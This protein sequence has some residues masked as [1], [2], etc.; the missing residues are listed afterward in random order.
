M[1]KI[2]LLITIITVFI[3]A[4]AE[5]GDP[6]SFY[7][8]SIY[9]MDESVF[10]RSESLVEI[11][12]GRP[13]VVRDKS[14]NVM[15]TTSRGEVM[16][17]IDTAGEM[18]FSIGGRREHHRGEDGEIEKR[19]VREAGTS[20][21]RVENERQE[22]L[23]YEEYGYGGKLVA[24]YDTE[25]NLVRSV[26]YNE[27]GK[28]ATL[29]VD[30]LTMSRTVHDE[31]GRAV[32][33]LDFEGNEVARYSYDDDT[34]RLLSRTDAYSNV[35]YFNKDG[36]MS[37]TYNRYGRLIA[38]YNYGKNDRGF[39]ALK[40][41]KNEESEIITFY[42]DGRQLYSVDMAGNIVTEFK[43]VGSRLVYSRELETDMI[44]WYNHG[45]PAYVTYEGKVEEKFYYEKGRLIGR[46]IEKDLTV[47]LYSHGMA[48]ATIGL[49]IADE[50]KPDL[51]EV[52]A[53]RRRFM[54]FEA[55]HYQR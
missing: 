29:T 14:G 23:A 44:T 45:R 52:A 37:E 19:W 33:E 43:W 51:E 22:T 27:Y 15:L 4:G 3:C 40:S 9:R 5:A 30:E 50:R 42:E 47:E 12:P 1:K 35:T 26:E 48:V 8:S 46:W 32:K 20:R 11:T 39:T 38:T 55:N 41:V 10:Q 25:N 13:L 53:L 7:P 28:I 6:Y 24:E 2:V 21:V 54:V 18:T 17:N 31:R 49:N 34:G 36:Q 16:V